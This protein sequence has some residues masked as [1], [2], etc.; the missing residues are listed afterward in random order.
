MAVDGFVTDQ[1]IAY[2]EARAAGG[3]GL[4]VV[5]VAGV[6]ESARYTS[7]VLMA[8]RATSASPAT[9][10]WPRPS[11]PTAARSSARSSTTAARSWSRGR[12]AA[13][14]A[15][16]V[17]RP[18]RALPRHAAG[19]ADRRSSRRSV[20]G[21]AS[22]AAAAPRRPGSTAW[23][24]S[25]ATATCRPSS[26]TRGSTCG[27]TA[28]AAARRTGS[29]S[30][31]RRSPAIRDEVGREPVVG[32]RISIDEIDARGADPGRGP[33]GARR[34]RRRRR[35]L[36][37]VSVVAGTSATLA[38]S[39]HIVPP[40]TVPNAY[41][42]PLAARAKAR[43]RACRSSSPGASTSRRRRSASSSSGQ[44]DAC[45]HDPGAD[46]RPAPAGQGGGRP[47]RRDPR[48]RRLQPGL[49]RPLPR[50][51]PDLLHPVPGERARAPVRR[52]S[53][54]PAAGPRRPGRRRRPRRAEGRGRG[55]R[56]RPPGDALRGRRAGSA[57]RSC[58]P[59]GCPAA[60][61]SAASS[62]TSPA[63]PSGPACGS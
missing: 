50:R 3:V 48:L 17:G 34:A 16:P 62:P 58:S 2:Q 25:P 10:A 44:A 15:R 24:S 36:D 26:S 47:D 52:G 35:S 33:A 60:P 42:A 7:H 38:G 37:Y 63:R 29:A 23:R 59:S 49:H 28:T 4:I 19:D 40:M 8:D 43:R 31:A 13:G 18:E 11:T 30:C 27:P 57:A 9:G 51:L 61:S 6:H 41:T 5:Q 46:L 39:D 20:R 32:L 14:R 1:L 45:V 55:G 56:A 53:S 21:Y 12:H 54:R 22:A